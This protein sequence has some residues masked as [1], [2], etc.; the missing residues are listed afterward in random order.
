MNKG[1]Y[2]QTNETSGHVR[3]LQA[4]KS[5]R[6]QQELPR[7]RDWMCLLCKY[8]FQGQEDNESSGRIWADLLSAAER[9]LRA[10]RV[11]VLREKLK[12]TARK[13]VTDIFVLLLW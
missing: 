1:D 10:P 12:A 3:K 9:N 6:L 4:V 8:P 5:N 13:R 7:K 2:T 11:E